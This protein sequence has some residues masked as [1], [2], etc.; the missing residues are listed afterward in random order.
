MCDIIFYFL[1]DITLDW[2]PQV[3]FLTKCGYIFIYVGETSTYVQ[4]NTA[5]RITFNF[6]DYEKQT[7]QLYKFNKF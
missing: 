6:E 1:D 2:Q 7:G 5:K 3:L 4:L